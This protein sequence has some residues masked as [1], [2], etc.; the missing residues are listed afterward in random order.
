MAHAKHADVPIMARLIPFRKGVS[1][2]KGLMPC[3]YT[4][5]HPSV[6][7]E[8]YMLLTEAHS[9]TFHIQALCFLLCPMIVN[10]LMEKGLVAHVPQRRRLPIHPAVQRC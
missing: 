2:G 8:E 7:P 6:I 10:G 4:L 1:R 5:L 3:A 9:Q